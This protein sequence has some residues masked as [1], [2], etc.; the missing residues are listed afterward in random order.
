MHYGVGFHFAYRAAYDCP[1][2]QIAL[3]EL[4]AGIDRF[5]VSLGQI[6]EDRNLVTFIEQLLDAN[7]ANVACSPS[8]EYGFHGGSEPIGK[9]FGDQ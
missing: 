7:T 9:I 5:A 3:K 8:D 1:V 2:S 4:G 6:I